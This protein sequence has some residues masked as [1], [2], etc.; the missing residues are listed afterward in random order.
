MAMVLDVE[1]ARPEAEEGEGIDSTTMQL[2]YRSIGDSPDPTTHVALD[3]VASP[4][5]ARIS[6]SML[7][8]MRSKSLG[9]G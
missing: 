7:G 5:T 2:S 8:S 3:G 9:R 1:D 6:T 4:I